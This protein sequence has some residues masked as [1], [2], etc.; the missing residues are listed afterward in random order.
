M[1][2][3]EAK[4]PCVTDL[5]ALTNRPPTLPLDHRPHRL[6]FANVIHPLSVP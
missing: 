6:H 2:R 3:D 5:P 1:K 4:S